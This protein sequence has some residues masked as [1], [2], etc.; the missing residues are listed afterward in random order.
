MNTEEFVKL[1][2]ENGVVDPKKVLRDMCYILYSKGGQKAVRDLAEDLQWKEWAICK[3]RFHVCESEEP[4]ME[5]ECLV[6]GSY[7]AASKLGGTT[8]ETNDDVQKD[9]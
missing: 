5:G 8:Y 6:C 1:G 2:I 3:S 9:F 4:H 7:L